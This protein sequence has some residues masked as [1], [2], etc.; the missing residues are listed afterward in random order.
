MYLDA[1]IRLRGVHQEKVPFSLLA[2]EVWWGTSRNGA[3]ISYHY[4]TG[5]AVIAG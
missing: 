2:G 5:Y 3:V 4:T 1:A